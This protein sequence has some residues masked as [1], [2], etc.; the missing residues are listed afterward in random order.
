MFTGIISRIGHLDSIIE[1][2]GGKQLIVRAPNFFLDSSLGDSVAVNGIC[3]TMTSFDADH[4]T[5]FAQIETINK[6]TIKTWKQNQSVNLE[7][8]L[9]LN[10]L[11]GGHLVQGHVDDIGTLVRLGDLQDGSRVIEIE[12]PIELKKYVVDRGSI[13]INGVSLTVAEKTVAGAKIS[14][15]PETIKNTTFE[16][17]ETGDAVNIEIDTIARY[18]EQLLGK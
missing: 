14:L 13:T 10:D 11:L 17:I 7:H 12:I 1:K 6:T 9:R 2:G 18:V 5:F 4:A 3:L 8:P 15:I 16:E